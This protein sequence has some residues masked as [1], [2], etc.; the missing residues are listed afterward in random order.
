MK[1]RALI[2]RNR[3]RRLLPDFLL[4]SRS[5]I[6]LARAFCAPSLF[7]FSFPFPY[8]G[9]VR[10]RISGTGIFDRV[11]AT[12]AL[13]RRSASAGRGRPRPFGASASRRAGREEARCSASTRARVLASGST[14]AQAR[15]APR[16]SH[17][18]ERERSDFH[19]RAFDIS[20]PAGAR[21]FAAGHHMSPPSVRFSAPAGARHFAAGHHIW[22]RSEIGKQDLPTLHGLK[23]WKKYFVISFRSFF[24]TAKNGCEAC[25][26]LFGCSETLK[27]S[28][29]FGS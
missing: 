7:F 2:V 16:S 22:R 15:R 20:A 14:P 19:H 10:I 8:C 23:Y 11:S 29:C 13:A 26:F 27:Q 12:S 24:L 4:Y 28:T 21:H 17:H 9:G 5:R 25:D 6:F 3:Q 1:F 18:H